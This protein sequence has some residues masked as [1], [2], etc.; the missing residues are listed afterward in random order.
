M[1]DKR[2]LSANLQQKKAK[3]H[4]RHGMM[5]NNVWK[6]RHTFEIYQNWI[7]KE[8]ISIKNRCRQRK[9]NPLCFYP[10]GKFC[11]TMVI[12]SE[13]QRQMITMLN[14]KLEKI[15]LNSSHFW[16]N[17]RASMQHTWIFEFYLHADIFVFVFR[18]RRQIAYLQ[19][20]IRFCWVFSNLGSHNHCTFIVCDYRIR[21]L[22][23]CMLSSDVSSTNLTLN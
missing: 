13:N 1:N 23:S 4:H 2:F 9:K 20:M 8:L 15:C 11:M 12:S 17:K 19:F 18:I 14:I 3:I 5:Y 10:N 6:C 21:I 7:W 22:I 16:W